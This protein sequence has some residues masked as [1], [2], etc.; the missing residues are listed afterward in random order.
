M[1]KGRGLEKRPAGERVCGSAFSTLS[2]SSFRMKVGVY[3]ECNRIPPIILDSQSLTQSDK[4]WVV[5]NRF[6]IPS[7]RECV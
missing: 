6:L 2:A 4:I 1:Y 5:V 7:P 3:V